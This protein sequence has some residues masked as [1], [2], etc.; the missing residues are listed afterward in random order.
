MEAGSTEPFPE[1]TWKFTR[2]PSVGVGHELEGEELVAHRF[3][4]RLH[5]LPVGRFEKVDA[6]ALDHH[7]EEGLS[8]LDLP[9][10]DVQGSEMLIYECEQGLIVDLGRADRKESLLAQ[11][12]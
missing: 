10:E 2:T 5:E 1:V 8:E 4:E 9:N 6:L 3:A 11:L 12:L 7:Q